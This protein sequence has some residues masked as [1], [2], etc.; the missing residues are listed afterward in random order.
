MKAHVHCVS[1]MLLTALLTP[2]LMAQ[3]VD[4]DVNWNIKHSVGG[5]SD[6]GR[7]RHITVHSSLTDVDWDGEEDKMD[8]LMNDLDVY[9]GRDNGASTWKFK[10]SVEDPNRPNHAD[11]AAMADYGEFLKGD[12]D[13]MTSRL[14]Y[15]SRQ[16]EMIMGTN[17]HPLY[18]TLSWYENG[19]TWDGWQ[20]MDVETS[21]EWVV[22]YLDF[23]FKKKGE[24]SGEKLPM[25]W[26][27]INE[28]DMT[29]MTGQFMVSSWESLWKYHN[30]VAAGVRERMGDDAP[31]IGGMTWGLH[32]FHKP[33]LA[34]FPSDN[35][36]QWI[37]DPAGAAFYREAADT[38]YP[39][40]GKDWEQWD[41]LWQLF[42]DNCGA[43]MDFYS[44]HIYDWPGRGL[45]I[46]PTIRTGGHVEGMLDIMEWYDVYKFGKSNRKPIVLSEYG[47]VNGNYINNSMD[48]LY[49]D[50]ECI[51]PW[52]SMLMQFLE[53]PDYLVKTMPFTPIKATWGD[54]SDTQRYPYSMLDRQV[55]GSTTNWNWSGY[56]KWYELWSDVEGTRI[57]TL[58]SD[59]DIQVDAY[60][61]GNKAYL[62]L[63][64]LEK[65]AKT[66]NLNEYGL[67]TSVRSVKVKHLYCE[68]YEDYK[69]TSGYPVLDEYTQ[70]APR[71]VT[72]QPEATMILQYNFASSVNPSQ[73]VVETK[74]YGSNLS[75]GNPFRVKSTTV[76]GS[77]N[78]VKVPSGS[79]EAVLR[80]SGMFWSSGITSADSRNVVTV[81]GNTIQ[82]GTDWRGDEGGSRWLG[83]L[84]I[85]VPISYL[86]QNN[87]I[88]CTLINNMDYACMGLQIF[89]FSTT[90]GRSSG[91]NPVDQPP[92][93]S[94]DSITK[95][96]ATEAVAY[97]GTISGDASDPDGDTL[98]FT[99]VSGP[100]WLSVAANGTL[101]GT[102]GVADRGVNS[103]TVQVSDG[104]AMDTA[105]LNITVNAAVSVN[106][107]PVFGSDPIRKANATEN[108]AY[109]ATISGSAADADGDSLTYSKVSGPAWLRV[110]S[111]GALSGTPAAGDVGAKSWTVKV[112][113]G[114][115]TDSATL[116][117]TVDSAVVSGQTP[118]G[119]T[120]RSLTSR[121]E[122]E[123]FDE[124]GEDVA[125]NDTSSGNSGRSYRTS[126]NV[127]IQGTSDAG[128]GYNV[129][130]TATAEW[131]EYTVNASSGTYDINLRV[132][133][134]NSGK[135]IRVVLDGVTLA[136]L[137]VPKTGGWQTWQ[138]V[139][140][141]GIAA[142]GRNGSV[143]RLEMVNGG[144]NVNWVEFESVNVTTPVSFT[145]QAEDFDVNG[146][147]KTYAA[148]G[149]TAINWVQA[150]EYVEYNVTVPQS[151]TYTI[152]YYISTPL[153]G[154]TIA[155][156][157]NGTTVVTDSVPNTGSWDVFQTATRSSSTVNLT[158]GANTIRLVAGRNAWQW[159]LDKVVLSTP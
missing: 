63:N 26:E 84:E 142:S 32:D 55:S 80:I 72:I 115:L 134:P 149:V 94:A 83:T 56:I 60:V 99:R 17:P 108:A 24:S 52:S 147:V 143:L 130:W 75:G 51:R 128:S 117:I 116:N 126:E 137:D 62:I 152:D 159:N 158:A 18:P 145:I 66:I 111:N 92:V 156:Q 123:D 131:L 132:A 153:T 121:I 54:Y 125:Y 129:G 68:N 39:R 85:P 144:V 88:T 102:P 14:P 43:N 11:L 124:G 127:D 42:V 8:Y 67:S 27:V 10:A 58:S 82:L 91:S 23:Y 25:Y 49:I 59:P 47:S 38:A 15:E 96:A 93:F 20:P 110:A 12:Y 5:V 45:S 77:I 87:T 35:Y 69:G 61:N 119:G 151:G 139:T 29:L 13:A 112:S 79:D 86:K 118:Y 140:A 78:G 34:R 100:S 154:S 53:R 28:P 31:L 103:W 41:K 46:S 104:T 133:S 114:S 107:A 81:N 76:S 44:V 48:G 57:E 73:S 89:D 136:T 9:F 122:A 36:D 146:G 70:S 109:S 22:N 71:S 97:R 2:N 90:P 113:D 141:A 157:L 19:S 148:G 135:K 101:S 50:W 64:N 120:A 150:N 16:Q 6:F 65:V 138:T 1:A 3:S 40:T 98:T 4:V 21:V 105:T 155:F 106:Q 95:T 30:L 7:E 74:Y 37:T 33:D